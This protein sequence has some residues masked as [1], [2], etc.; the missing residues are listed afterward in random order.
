MH[1]SGPVLQHPMRIPWILSPPHLKPCTFVPRLHVKHLAPLSPWP[2][3][4]GSFCHL[5]LGPSQLHLRLGAVI[6]SAFRTRT[7]C[8]LPLSGQD[9]R[10]PSIPGLGQTLPRGPGRRSQVSTRG[11]DQERLGENSC[12]AGPCSEHRPTGTDRTLVLCILL[13]RMRYSS[14]Y[15][16]LSICQVQA[17][18]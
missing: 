16:L 5:P 2:R 4:P 1:R 8:S 3:P 17:L 6:R 15:Y 11:P 13:E 14:D 10:G 9:S 7:P 12:P 18:S